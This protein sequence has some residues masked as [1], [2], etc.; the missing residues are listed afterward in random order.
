MDIEAVKKIIGSRSLIGDKAYQV[1][2][3]FEKTEDNPDGYEP[4]MG[5]DTGGAVELASLSVRA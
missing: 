2:Q 3:L 4:P 5:Y 1:C